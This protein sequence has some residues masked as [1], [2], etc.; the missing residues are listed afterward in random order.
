MNAVSSVSLATLLIAAA[1]LCGN[2]EDVAAECFAKE[3]EAHVTQQFSIYWA[4][5]GQP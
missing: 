1:T 2:A 5:I 4:A 3:V